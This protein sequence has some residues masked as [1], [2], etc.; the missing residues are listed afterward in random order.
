MQTPTPIRQTSHPGDRSPARL[1][2]AWQRLRET[3]PTLRI[4]D[5]AA[6]LGVAEL[7]LLALDCGKTVTRLT[8]PWNELLHGLPR[9]GPVMALTRNEYAVHEK[10]GRY[11]KISLNGATGLVLNDAIDL[12]LF[13]D[14]WRHGYAVTETG[15]DGEPRRSLQFFDRYGQAV[16]KVYIT[17]DSHSGHY[18]DLVERHAVKDQSPGQPVDIKPRP[19]PDMPDSIVDRASLAGHWRQLRD[20]HDFHPMLRQRGVGRLQAMRLAA[21]DLAWPVSN[22]SAQYILQFVAGEAIP[23]M[24]FVASPGT[25]QIHTGPVHN[26]RRSGPWINVLDEGFNLHLRDAC[27]ASSWVVRKPTEDGVVTSLELFDDRDELV[28]QFFG[29]RKPGTPELDAW[30]DLL[31]ALPPAAGTARELAA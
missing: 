27:L 21:R 10:H 5:A 20:T 31:D 4:R 2:A 25:V 17:Q 30:R 8:G 28:V 3:E 6:R 16:H 15:A 23:I 11:G 19:V 13:L 12:R 7:E 22:A 14:H 18:A 26:L 29:K 9:L 1:E 24:V